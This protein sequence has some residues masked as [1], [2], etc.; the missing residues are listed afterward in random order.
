[1]TTRKIVAETFKMTAVLLFCAFVIFGLMGCAGVS[2]G[3]GHLPPERVPLTRPID[4]RCRVLGDILYCRV[5]RGRV[6]GCRCVPGRS[7]W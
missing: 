6:T 2:K 3:P 7:P 4:M 5:A 1:M